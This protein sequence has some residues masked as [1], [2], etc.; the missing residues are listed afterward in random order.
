MKS[1]AL[2]LLGNECCLCGFSGS[3]AAMQFH[4]VDPRKKEVNFNDSF[5]SWD[6]YKKELEKCILLC[7]NCHATVHWMENVN[8]E[9]GNN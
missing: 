4:H 9:V 5:V 7:A 1:R 3:P 8:I 2:E 6:R